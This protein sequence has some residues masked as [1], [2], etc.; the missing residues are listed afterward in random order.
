MLRLHASGR[1]GVWRLYMSE[2]AR[3]ASLSAIQDLDCLVVDSAAWPVSSIGT[4]EHK[5]T[6]LGLPLGGVSFVS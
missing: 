2:N 4:W 1:D 6:F 5:S 3:V